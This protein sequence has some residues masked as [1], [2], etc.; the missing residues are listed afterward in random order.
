MDAA[1]QYALAYALTT[2]A[3]VRAVLALAAVAVATHVGLLHPPAMFLWLASVPVMWALL[4][5][6][7][8]EVLADKVPFLDHALHVLQ[9]V[10][11]PAAAAIIVGGTVHAQ[12]NEMLI[13]LM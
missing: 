3:G 1:T 5:V 11:K 9:I 2:T 4:G 12:S 6:A 7:A 10:V 8:V 13:F